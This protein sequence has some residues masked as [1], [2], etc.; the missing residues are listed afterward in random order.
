MAI[1][2]R[3]TLP[4]TLHDALSILLFE[5]FWKHFRFLTLISTIPG[6]FF[7]TKNRRRLGHE[8]PLYIRLDPP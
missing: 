5:T 1:S 4:L 2:V 6:G 7:L 8:H 3:K